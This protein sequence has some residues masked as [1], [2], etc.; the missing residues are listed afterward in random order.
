VLVRTKSSKRYRVLKK[1]ATNG[2]GYWSLSSS[3]R[4]AFWRVRWTSP[5]G[6]RYDGPPIAAS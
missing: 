1:V 4:G 6:K 2:S 5:S 3:V